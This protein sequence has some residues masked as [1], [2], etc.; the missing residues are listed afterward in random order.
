MPSP[1]PGNAGHVAVIAALL[2]LTVWWGRQNCLQT[3]VTQSGQSWDEGSPGG[4]R[5]LERTA[6]PAWE[7][8]EGFQEEGMSKLS[9]KR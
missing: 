7:V 4:C 8:R 2:G 9:L 1:R 5:S 3:V 6:D